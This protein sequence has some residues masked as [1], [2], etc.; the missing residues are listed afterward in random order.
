MNEKPKK[1]VKESRKE[2]ERV[3]ESFN[4]KR[5]LKRIEDRYKKTK[6]FL[7]PKINL[8]SYVYSDDKEE[9]FFFITKVLANSIDDVVYSKFL[10]V[11]DEVYLRKLERYNKKELLNDFMKVELTIVVRDIKD[12]VLT[13]FDFKPFINDM[14][15]IYE[16]TFFNTENENKNV[17]KSWFS[18]LYKAPG[19]ELFYSFRIIKEK[20]FRERFLKEITK[21][22]KPVLDKGF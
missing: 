1:V 12:K 4:Q 18:N 21:N 7:E 20:V 6:V 16:D 11:L 10:G 15:N 13:Q 22:L 2:P 8:D 14:I 17:N 19:S 5:A 3:F 9:S